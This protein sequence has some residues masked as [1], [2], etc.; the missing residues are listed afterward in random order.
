MYLFLKAQQETLI[1]A[2][3]HPEAHRELL[4]RIAGYSAYFVQL[5]Q[6]MQVEVINRNMQH[7]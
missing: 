4:V 5:N 1:D 2:H 6:E 3:E 7:L